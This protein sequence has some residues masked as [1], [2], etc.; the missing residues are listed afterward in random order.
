MIKGTFEFDNYP[1]KGVACSVGASVSGISLPF[2]FTYTNKNGTVSAETVFVESNPENLGKIHSFETYKDAYA[3]GLI[4]AYFNLKDDSNFSYTITFEFKEKKYK[5]QKTP[6][7]TGDEYIK[8][9][10]F[11]DTETLSIKES[12]V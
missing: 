10:Y 5:I 12:D 7:F 4:V 8:V 11:F 3:L 2:A 1:V 6:L 9:M